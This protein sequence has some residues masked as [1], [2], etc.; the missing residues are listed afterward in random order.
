MDADSESVIG[1][2][3]IMVDMWQPSL[4]KEVNSEKRRVSVFGV[5]FSSGIRTFFS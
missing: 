1:S 3:C 5:K 4:R 2:I